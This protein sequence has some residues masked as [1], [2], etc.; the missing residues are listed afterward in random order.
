MSGWTEHVSDNSKA[1]QGKSTRVYYLADK[2]T[3][4]LL[5]KKQVAVRLRTKDK[6]VEMK[7]NKNIRQK[8]TLCNKVMCACCI[9]IVPCPH[10]QAC[11]VDQ[12]LFI[13]HVLPLQ[14]P[15]ARQERPL[16]KG[17]QAYLTVKHSGLVGT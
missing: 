8:E 17:L 15:P 13:L 11:P 3:R 7:I 4:R 1:L 2:E 14:P 5:S 16:P 10:L 9:P 12:A 6:R